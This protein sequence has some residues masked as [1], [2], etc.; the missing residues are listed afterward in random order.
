VESFAASRGRGGQV[1]VRVEDIVSCADIMTAYG[2]LGC[3][4]Q[5]VLG[6]LCDC[7]VCPEVLPAIDV[8]LRMAGES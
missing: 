6:G 7:P 3:G 1:R 4:A 2:F 5:A 8:L